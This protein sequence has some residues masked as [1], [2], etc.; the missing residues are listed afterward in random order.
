MT[1]PP[2]TCNHRTVEARASTLVGPCGICGEQS[3]TE[4]GFSPSSSVF[5]CQN[6]STIALDV[7]ISPGRWTTGPLVAT[8]Q[9]QQIHLLVTI[10]LL[11]NSA[12]IKWRV[13]IWVL[14]ANTP[15]GLSWQLLVHKCREHLL[16]LRA[17]YYGICSPSNNCIR[18]GM[19]H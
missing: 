17:N 7:H 3:G 18:W 5:S 9:R 1:R 19:G 2:S 11:F 16:C 10:S 6:H 15:T 8:V 4:A 13:R 14:R 12:Y